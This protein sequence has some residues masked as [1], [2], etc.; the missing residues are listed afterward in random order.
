MYSD[1]SILIILFSSPNI[2]SAR[3]LES[4]VFPTPV[5]PKNINDPIGLLGSFNPTLALLT[6]LA[7][8]LTA[9]L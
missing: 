8:D 6:A 1:I 5:G 2:A 4:S 3:A 7:T 9:S